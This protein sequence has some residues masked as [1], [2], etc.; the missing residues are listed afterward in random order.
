[1]P[2]P[3]GAFTNQCYTYVDCDRQDVVTGKPVAGRYDGP[4][5]HAS[6]DVNMCG[7]DG[8]KTGCSKT[9]TGTT[10]FKITVSNAVSF[11]V[12]FIKDTVTTAFE[13]QW[14]KTYSNTFTAEGTPRKH[15]WFYWDLYK[16]IDV[17]L[18]IVST[19]T[20]TA[21]FSAKNLFLGVPCSSVYY[22][23]TPVTYPGG[24][25]TSTAT[26]SDGFGDHVAIRAVEVPCVE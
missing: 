2:I 15:I 21:G 6:C 10:S 16:Q 8:G 22:D 24:S 13:A 7:T 12:K 3:L 18:P 25:L 26:L 20:C 5:N 1:M 19:Y 4:V 14:Q 11:D 17:T 23:S 9:L